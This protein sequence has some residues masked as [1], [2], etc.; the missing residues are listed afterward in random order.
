[1]KSRNIFIMAILFTL[2]PLSVLAASNSSGGVIRFSGN[3][4]ADSCSTENMFN[5]NENYGYLTCLHDRGLTRS[6]VSTNFY[7]EKNVSYPLVKSVSHL[8][9][10]ENASQFLISYN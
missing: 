4:V 5:S 7:A 10:S 6:T 8:R 9:L 2:A 3:I 1:M